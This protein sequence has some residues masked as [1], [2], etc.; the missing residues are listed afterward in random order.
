MNIILG[1]CIALQS[2]S[3]SMQVPPISISGTRAPFLRQFAYIQLHSHATI[4]F[5]SLILFRVTLVDASVSNVHIKDLATYICIFWR[6][7]SYC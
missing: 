5:R 1:E 6:L 4:V 7:Y 3:W 2:G